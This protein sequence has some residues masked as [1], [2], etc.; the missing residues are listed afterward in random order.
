ME[1]RFAATCFSSREFRRAGSP[2]FAFIVGVAQLALSRWV[3]RRA[4]TVGVVTLSLLA[5]VI[6][7]EFGPLAASASAAAPPAAAQVMSAPDLLS[8]GMA[9][10]AQNIRVEALSERTESSLTFV[11]P[12]GTTTLDSVS[13]PVRVRQGDGSWK[14]V[15][16]TLVKVAGR[17]RP[18]VA[19]YHGIAR[20]YGWGI[21]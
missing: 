21:I 15:S 11:N 17:Y 18:Q 7:A 2:Q 14:D 13:E 4:A 16:L 10:R 8:A 3:R 6:P 9:A 20:I 5:A 12:D 1:P 19:A